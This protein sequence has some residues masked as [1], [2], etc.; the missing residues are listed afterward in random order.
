MV[1][2]YVAFVCVAVTNSFRFDCNGQVGQES[3]PCFFFLPLNLGSA[4]DRREAKPSR[5]A[6]EA[7]ESGFSLLGDDGMGECGF[8]CLFVLVT[9]AILITLLRGREEQQQWW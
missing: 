3:F 5:K 9:A 1:H 2:T 8:V 6:Q 4:W 7:S